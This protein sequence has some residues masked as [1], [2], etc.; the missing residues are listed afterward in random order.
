MK[1]VRLAARKGLCPLLLTVFFLPALV[2]ALAAP[3]FAQDEADNQ[4]YK[5]PKIAPE[6][7]LWGGF[8]DAHLGG[9]S[10]ALPYGYPYD[11]VS[12]GGEIIAFPFPNRVHLELDALNPKDYYADFRYAYSDTVLSR[13]LGSS[14]FHNLPNITLYP[15]RS[16]GIAVD[17]SDIGAQYGVREGINRVFLRFKTHDYPLHIYLEGMDVVQSGDIQQIFLGDDSLGDLVR[18]AQE[19]AVDMRTTDVKVGLNGHLGP[20]EMDYSHG[21]KRFSADNNVMSFNYADPTQLPLHNLISE[22]EGSSDTFRIH[23]SYTGMLYAMGT[24]SKISRTNETSGAQADYF[25]G[26]AEMRI[27]PVTPVMLVARYKHEELSENNASA[28]DFLDALYS[29]FH[30]EQ[31]SFVAN[32]IRPPISSVTDT[33]TGVARYRVMHNLTAGGEVSWSNERRENYQ[34]WLDGFLPAST[35]HSETGFNVD[36]LPVNDLKLRA[37]YRHEW[38]GSPAYNYQP[39]KSDAGTLSATWTFPDG[40][41]AFASYELDHETRG[42]LLIID[43]ETSGV[44]GAANRDVRRDKFTGDVA[45]PVMRNITLDASYAY[46]RSKVRQDLIY[47]TAGGFSLDPQV[48]YTDISHNYTVSVNYRPVKRLDLTAAVNR[49]S[50]GGDFSSGSQ[51]D[52]SGIPLSAFSTLDIK[53]TVY[54][55]KTRWTVREKMEVGLSY[56]YSDF[57]SAFNSLNPE[58][59][60][61]HAHTFFASLTKK[62]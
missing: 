4:V 8:Y 29:Q 25:F 26:N 10:S 9:G 32:S 36:Y 22:L 11:S 58:Y 54:S 38:Y 7:S 61:G 12:L 20:V 40:I 17:Q 45:L 15:A 59:V 19:R 31:P 56:F 34:F 16:P 2:A 35:R 46:W 21:F 14:L 24:L 6:Y 5:Y 41:V 43:Y 39:D 50:A 51:F 30:L 1:R 18:T 62:W 28:A 3:S 49:F 13:F 47:T 55:L 52:A 37:A 33:V 44:T 53:E 60:S 27:I 23:T 57:D 48:P 42:N